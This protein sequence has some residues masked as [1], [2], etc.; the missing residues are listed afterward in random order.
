[1]KLY[2]TKNHSLSVDFETAVFN[3]LPAD[4]GLYMPTSFPQLDPEVISGWDHKSLPEV[5]FDLAFALLKD[6]ISS[7][8]L[9][10]II[11]EAA[12]FDAPLHQLQEDVYV[13]ELFHGPSLA[14]KDFGARFMSRIMAHFLKKE[15]KEIRI[16]V[17]TSG[18]TGGAVALGF[19]KDAGNKVAIL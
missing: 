6:D 18:D 9:K 16:L 12:N 14:F 11:D 5:A 8:E 17:A 2:S 13:L 3:S 7:G 4:K 15:Q 10:A 1:M 19:L